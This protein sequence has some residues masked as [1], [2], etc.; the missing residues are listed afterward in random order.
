[1]ST[2]HV[3]AGCA[4]RMFWKTCALKCYLDYKKEPETEKEGHLEEFRVSFRS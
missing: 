3:A 2:W 1:M 4:L